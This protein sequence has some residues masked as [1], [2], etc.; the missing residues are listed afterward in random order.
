[1]RERRQAERQAAPGIKKLQSFQWSAEDQVAGNPE[2]TVK[3]DIKQATPITIQK[4]QPSPP[5]EIIKRAKDPVK[6]WVDLMLD[7]DWKGMEVL[8]TAT[9]T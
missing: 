9:Q 5:L 7:E 4:R 2:P 6:V 3:G 1:M 8:P